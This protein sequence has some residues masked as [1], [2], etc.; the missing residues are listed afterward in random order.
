M[1]PL[2]VV[3]SSGWLEYLADTVRAPLFAQPIEDSE[4]LLVPSIVLLEVVKK[5]LRERGDAVAV[6]VAAALHAGKLVD[7]DSE[8]AIK[9]T[10]IKLPLADSIIYAT[11][12]KFD[13]TLWTQDEHLKGLPNVHYFEKR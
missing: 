12:L 6:Q 9:A 5:V 10:R 1:T 13:A 3:D 11:T 4:H 2:N 7:L 8:L